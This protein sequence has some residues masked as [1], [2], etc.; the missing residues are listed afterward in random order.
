MNE[1]QDKTE[2]MMTPC[3]SDEVYEIDGITI[4]L[5][6]A[7]ESNPTIMEKLEKLLWENM[8]AR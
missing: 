4:R 6:Y 8:L 1:G 2:K 7:K 5:H 3:P